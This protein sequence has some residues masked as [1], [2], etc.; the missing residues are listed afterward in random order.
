MKTQTY[1]AV[2][3]EKDE[4]PIAIFNSEWFSEENVEKWRD[5]NLQTG[6]VEEYKLGVK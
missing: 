5:K 6:I 2:V 1:Y 3:P 4:T